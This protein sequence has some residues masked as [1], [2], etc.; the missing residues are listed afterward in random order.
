V[1]SAVL[2]PFLSDLEDHFYSSCKDERE[3]E[4]EEEKQTGSQTEI[5]LFD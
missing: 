3:K 2:D 5:E 4:E 1:C